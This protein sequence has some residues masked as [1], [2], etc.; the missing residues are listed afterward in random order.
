MKKCNIMQ[1]T[2]VATACHNLSIIKAK[3]W[4]NTT[5]NQ[6][7]EI[8]AEIVCWH[9]FA[10]KRNLAKGDPSGSECPS[11]RWWSLSDV[12]FVLSPWNNWSFKAKL[13][14][15]GLTVFV[16]IRF[17]TKQ[18]IKTTF[19]YVHLNVHAE[20]FSSKTLFEKKHWFLILTS[21]MMLITQPLERCKILKANHDFKWLFCFKTIVCQ[22][23]CV[24][25]WYGTFLART[26]SSHS[27]KPR[28]SL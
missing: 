20:Q 19:T 11:S 13:K 28:R 10:S 14:L 4:V 3:K 17:A 18:I 8:P 27:A 6:A 5:K 26:Y 9:R 15:F 23:I 12:I 16:C 2:N 22:Q 21:F 25:L 1:S 7:L 24:R